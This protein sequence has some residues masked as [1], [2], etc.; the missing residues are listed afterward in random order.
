MK[1]IELTDEAYKAVLSMKNH[2][3][4]KLSGITNPEMMDWI[5]KNQNENHIV[6]GVDKIFPQD[7]YDYEPDYSYST[8]LMELI[9]SVLE[10]QQTGKVNYIT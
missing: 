4:I 5:N 2:M 9:G 6:K 3:T 10:E 8:F 7:K 1:T